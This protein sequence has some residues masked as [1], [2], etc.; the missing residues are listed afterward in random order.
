M[1]D[2]ATMTTDEA[3]QENDREPRFCPYCGGPTVCA[4]VADWRSF[5][6]AEVGNNAT[7]FEHQCRGKCEGR[8][9]W[10]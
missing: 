6:L 10:T 4:F 1:S 7:L 2:N 3:P 9:F 8:S 5:S